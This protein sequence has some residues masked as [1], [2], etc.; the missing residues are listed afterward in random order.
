MA[1]AVFALVAFAALRMTVSRSMPSPSVASRLEGRPLP[2]LTAAQGWPRSALPESLAGRVVV[3]AFL[4]F[5][6]PRSLRVVP[7]LEAWHEAYSRYGLRVLGVH[8]PAFAFAADTASSARDVARLGIRFPVALDPSLEVWRA[9]DGEGAAPR[10]VVADPQG[11]V[12]WDREGLE[13]LPGAERAIR[14]LVLR[15]HRGLRFPAGSE[16]SPGSESFMHEAV[17]LGRARVAHGPLVDAVPGRAASFTAQLRYQVEGTP[18]T[19]YPVG[20]WTPA[21]D[22]LVAA[23][24]GAENFVAL[25][26]DAG[27]LGAVL[28]PSDAGPTRIWVLRDDRWLTPERAGADVQIDGRGASYVMVN[29][30]RLYALV[31]MERGDHVVKLSPDE[32]GAT[33]YAFTFEPFESNAA[34]P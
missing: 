24:G 26:Y 16:P 2:P 30:P 27:A 34:R 28:G 5:D 22:G 23:R 33:I 10:I 29:E 32:S 8:V 21:A 25:R 4:S 14:A 1:V 3:V 15:S 12:A 17:H 19:P 13:A 6:L 18:Y 11:K 7:T 31:R 9:F 20:R